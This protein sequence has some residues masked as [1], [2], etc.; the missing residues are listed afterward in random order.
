MKA[1]AILVGAMLLSTNAWAEQLTV[2]ATSSLTDA[3][4]EIASL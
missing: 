1:L 4:K 3:M 2:L